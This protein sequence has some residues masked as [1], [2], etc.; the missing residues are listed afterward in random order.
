M[1]A[2]QRRKGATGERELAQFLRSVIGIDAER[3]ARNGCDQAEDIHHGIVGLHIEC[4]RV[5]RLNVSEAM[6]QAREAAG[7]KIPTVW[8]RRSREPWLLTICAEDLMG[9]I[10]LIECHRER[11][12]A[13]KPWQPEE[14]AEL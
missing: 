11:Q 1:G 6:K 5:E 4:K 12:A 9:F 7:G 8:H 14:T 3:S 13:S 10:D 2:S